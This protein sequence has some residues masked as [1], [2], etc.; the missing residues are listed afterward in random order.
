MS[1]VAPAPDQRFSLLC[2]YP[3]ESRAVIHQRL[4]SRENPLLDSRRVSSG[5]Y[6]LLYRERI[7]D[8]PYSSFVPVS[9]FSYIRTKTENRAQFSLERD[10]F[11]CDKG[12]PE[13][14]R[15]GRTSIRRAT[16]TM[17]RSHR[18]VET[19]AVHPVHGIVRRRKRLHRSRFAHIGLE[20]EP[21]S[22]IPS[23]QFPTSRAWTLLYSDLILTG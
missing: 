19:S 13:N 6:I 16:N 22:F 2:S 10:R 9:F 5:Q 17:S 12:R 23:V 4:L 18:N 15:T 11:P 3:R 20:R 1:S 14:A 21:R 7:M 8:R